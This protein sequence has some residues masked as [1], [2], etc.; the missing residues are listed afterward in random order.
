MRSLATLV[1]LVAMTGSVAAQADY[2]WLSEIRMQA[3]EALDCTV[4]YFLNAREG[5]L[6]GK[7][8]Q[9]ARMQCSDG[10][11]FDAVRES[12]SGPFRFLACDTQ[13]C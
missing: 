1:L 6:G 7:A 9:E 13:V 8:T 2:S 5:T 11:R 3:S 10:R 12:T 4:E